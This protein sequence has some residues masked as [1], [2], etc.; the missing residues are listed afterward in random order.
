MIS[1]YVKVVAAIAAAALIAFAFAATYQH[2]YGVA[3]AKGNQALS[4]YKARQA[5]ESATAASQA[6][7]KYADNVLR[8]QHAEVQFLTDQGATTAQIGTLKE[9]IDAVAQPHVSPPPRTSTAASVV[10]IDRCVFTR[11]FVSVWN[12]AA[13]IADGADGALQVRAGSGSV[14]GASDT[15]AAADS[16]VS[17]QDVLDWFVDY[18]A[19]ARKTELK[20]KGVKAA[21]PEQEDKQ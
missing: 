14:A 5:S 6:F 10:T 11:G 2:G 15:D 8:G 18:A 12:A 3:E 16:G 4:D 19:R 17:Q 21:L 1:K 7:G 13:G 9:H 20:L